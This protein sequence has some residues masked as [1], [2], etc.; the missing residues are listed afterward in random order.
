LNQTTTYSYAVQ[1]AV[2]LIGSASPNLPASPRGVPT[3]ITDPKGGKTAFWVN[4]RDQV[5]RTVQDVG[6]LG[7]E[8]ENIYD[9][10][11]NVIEIGAENVNAITNTDDMI[12]TRSIFD[13]LDEETQTVTDAGGAAA[14][15]TLTSYDAS[16][17][18]TSVKAGDNLTEQLTTYDE[19]DL[20]IATT[21]GATTPEAATFKKNYDPAGNL[22]V[23]VDAAENTPATDAADGVLNGDPTFLAYDGFNRK[24]QEVNELGA[25][26]LTQYDPASNIVSV[27]QQD[28]LG[29]ILKQINLTYD[30]RNRLIR[31]D[32]VILPL[33]VGVIHDVDATPGDSKSTRYMLRDGLDRTVA[34]IDEENIL[35]KTVYDGLS[36]VTQTTDAAGN[37]VNSTYDLNGNLLTTTEVDKS[38]VDA[39]T[40]SYVTTYTYD[41]LNRK[42]TQRE[43]DA[44]TTTSAYDSRDNV[45]QTTDADGNVSLNTYDRRARLVKEETFLSILPA[46]TP[47]VAQ[48]ATSASKDVAQSGD[49]IITKQYQ[50]DALD[51]LLGLTDDNGKTVSNTFNHLSQQVQ[52]K[53]PDLSIE[54][55][56]FN[57]DGDQLTE[58]LQDGTVVTHTYDDS[59]RLLTETTT[60]GDGKTR[61]GSSAKSWTYD[62]LGRVVTTSDNNDP[63]TPTDDVAYAYVYDSLSRQI[64]E[65]QTIGGAA[66]LNVDTEWDGL[67]G[68]KVLT[69]YPNGR[70]V[71]RIYDNGSRLRSINEGAINGPLIARYEYIGAENRVLKLTYGNGAAQ[72]KD[73]D[74]DRKVTRNEWKRSDGSTTITRYLTTYDASNRRLSEDRQHLGANNV[75]S[76]AFDADY[77][78]ARFRQDGSAVGVGGTLS[79]RILDGADMMTAF[80][81]KGINVTPVPGSNGRSQY[82]SFNGKTRAYDLNGNLDDQNTNDATDASD[83]E[84]MQ[85]YGNRIVEV[86]DGTYN[87]ASPAPTAVKARYAYDAGGRRVLKTVGATVTRYLYDGWQVVEERSGPSVGT[88]T[89]NRQYVDGEDL[90]DHIQMRNVSAGGDTTYYYHSNEQGFV[91]AL[92][93]STSAPVEYY[94]YDMMGRVS[95]LNPISPFAPVIPIGS[96]VGNPY[97]FQGRALDAE[98]GLY[99]FRYRYYD[100]AVGQFLTIDPL[101]VWNH[102][103]GNGYSAFAENLWDNTDP[104]GLDIYHDGTN[105]GGDGKRAGGWTP[106]F[107][108]FL[109]NKYEFEGTRDPAWTGLKIDF[110][111][112]VPFSAIQDL[113][114][115]YLNGAVDRAKLEELTASLYVDSAERAIME[116]ARQTLIS[117]VGTQPPSAIIINANKLLV[118]LNN[119]KGNVQFGDMS[120]NRSIGDRFDLNWKMNGAGL[121]VL[122]DRSEALFQAWKARVGFARKGEGAEEE[123]LSS[124]FESE[125]NGGPGKYADSNVKNNPN[126]KNRRDKYKSKNRQQHSASSD[127]Y[128]KVRKSSVNSLYHPY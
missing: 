28:A 12:A 80:T 75:D 89:T 26:T 60:A 17:N 127:S 87:P 13:L 32:R 69:T 103:Q 62:G 82:T 38:S 126:L 29:N 83:L 122:C 73:Y 27:T 66:P 41:A 68:R 3:L 11:D 22:A 49:G 57:G 45:V 84:F 61:G 108:A 91:G 30:E 96:T 20:P 93:D 5:I 95:V 4:E 16:E 120:I 14:T 6:G 79:S 101:G 18:V 111:H 21:Y 99:Y 25:K 113:L 23:L 105:Y 115:G 88:A 92:T 118:L 43:P 63:L 97:T 40:V 42:L 121:W 1:N 53:H 55:P 128:D 94:K 114:V 52:T 74:A 70:K 67:S 76:Y 10:N 39:T 81:S 35:F 47:G 109:R 33:T 104:F 98:S 86:R 8:T 78:M 54:T 106:E 48:T 110:T 2:P 51:R 65:T 7:Y 15:T 85:D 100:P 50:Y 125:S 107:T 112:L 123:I 58:T 9:A 77:R 24:I 64:R 119:S 34:V 124:Q 36:R 116:T 56:V 37:I 59:G 71:Y 31:S 19:R 102:G 44:S 90:D 72:T 46:T 117:S